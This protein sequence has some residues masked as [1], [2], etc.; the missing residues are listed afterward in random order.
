MPGLKERAKTLVELLDNAAF[1]YAKR[2]LALDDKAAGL[3][4]NGGRER[5][6]GA[7]R[8]LEALPDWT[9][10]STEGA[11]R[12]AERPMFLRSNAAII[13]SVEK[14]SWSPWLQ[15]RRTR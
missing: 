12:A 5:L 8:M 15:P 6:A 14:I 4:S 2:P 7:L 3:L 11:V 10:E 9:V 1:L 13:S